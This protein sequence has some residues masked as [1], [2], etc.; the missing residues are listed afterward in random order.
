MPVLTVPTLSLT[1]KRS[2]NV[3]ITKTAFLSFPLEH[4][5]R[6]WFTYG[7]P[8]TME[9]NGLGLCQAHNTITQTSTTYHVEQSQRRHPKSVN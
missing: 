7:H 1:D 4:V 2:I 5:P 6:I 8:V 9:G 3:C